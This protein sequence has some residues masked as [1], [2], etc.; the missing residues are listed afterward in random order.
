[1]NAMARADAQVMTTV[2]SKPR[3]VKHNLD[4]VTGVAIL[5]GAAAAFSGDRMLRIDLK[6]YSRAYYGCGTPFHG[7]ATCANPDDASGP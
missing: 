4:G 3:C 6:R 2:D 1:V 5:G 7:R